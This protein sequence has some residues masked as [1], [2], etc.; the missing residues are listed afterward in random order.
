MRQE[1]S[2]I[3]WVQNFFALQFNSQNS[4]HDQIC[5][6]AAVELH[7]FI[8]ERNRLLALDTHAYYLKL[9]R[10]ACFVCGFQ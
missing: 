4:V 2:F 5:T 8:K 1:L 9:V 7:P 6:K 10:E 3:N